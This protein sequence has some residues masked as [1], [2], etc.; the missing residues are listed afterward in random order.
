MSQKMKPLILAIAEKLKTR[1]WKLT[2][3]ESCTGGGIAFYLTSIA[4]SSDWFERGFVTYSNHSKEELVGVQSSTLNQF[5]AVSEQT[6]Q[7]MAEGA[8]T[9][10]QAQL[11]LA[12]TGIAGPTGGSL[13]KPVGTV[14]FA[15]ASHTASTRSFVKLLAGDRT[16]IREQ[17]IRVAC[18][19]LLHML[20]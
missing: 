10:S 6:A 3:A 18:E 8:L 16:D 15:Y 2:T 9:H 1:H 14:W 17:T 12:V 19:E 7:E 4:G 13:D 20:A 11:S 5:G